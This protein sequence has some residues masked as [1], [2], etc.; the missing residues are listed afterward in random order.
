MKW[1]AYHSKA[2]C[3]DEATEYMLLFEDGIEAQFLL[4][5]YELFTLKCYQTE[6]GKDYKRIIMY[7]CTVVYPP[8]ISLVDQLHT[9]LKYLLF[10]F[11][12]DFLYYIL[13]I[14]Y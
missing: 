8:T 6:I 11:I 1:K 4:G 2:N 12:Y 9:G 13:V 10:L 7:L 14:L 3:Y 5:T